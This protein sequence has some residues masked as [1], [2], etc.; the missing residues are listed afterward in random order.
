MEVRVSGR[1]RL[2]LVA[3]ALTYSKEIEYSGPVFKNMEISDNRAVLN[4]DHATGGLVSRNQKQAGKLSFFAIAGKDRVWHWA[5]A[6]IESD[7]VVVSSSMV[8]VP[9]A[10]R[11]A[12][13]PNVVC[14]FYNQV[15]LPASPF[16]TDDWPL[17]TEGKIYQPGKDFLNAWQEVI[18]QT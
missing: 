17:S 11:Y 18:N 4:F 1:R 10:V 8:P 13:T 7:T 15:G 5:D 3:L 16:R 2:G 14:D 12:W 9:A 6:V